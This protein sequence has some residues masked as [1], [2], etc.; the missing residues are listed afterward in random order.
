M[1]ATDFHSKGGEVQSDVWDDR[2]TVNIEQI[3]QVLRDAESGLRERIVRDIGLFTVGLLRVEG[4]RASGPHRN[5]NAGVIC[6][7]SLHS[8]RIS[9]LG[10]TA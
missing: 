10:R 8:D 6:R 3:V 1:A 5:W 4:R 2:W 9:C 7:R